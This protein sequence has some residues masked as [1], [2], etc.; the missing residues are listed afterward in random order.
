MPSKNN[1]S[2]VHCTLQYCSTLNFTILQYTKPYNTAV[3]CTIL[4]YRP[5]QRALG[6]EGRRG[7]VVKKRGGSGRW[8]GGGGGEEGKEKNV[9]KSSGFAP[10]M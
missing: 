6:M 9:K 1:N 7:R 5:H 8:R 10:K 2:V 3:H 4:L